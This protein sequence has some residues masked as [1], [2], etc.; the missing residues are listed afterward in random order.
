MTFAPAG[1]SVVVFD[2]ITGSYYSLRDGAAKAWLQIT[3]LQTPSRDYESLA[4]YADAFAARGLMTS[5]GQASPP[6]FD[7]GLASEI[8]RHAEFDHLILQEAGHD[9]PL[10]RGTHRA[11]IPDSSRRTLVDRLRV[12][13]FTSTLVQEAHRYAATQPMLSFTIALGGTPMRVQVPATDSLASIPI[14]E[15]F[16]PHWEGDADAADYCIT[17]IDDATDAPRRPTDFELDWHFPLGILGPE[18][19]GDSRVTVDRHTQTVSA[20]IPSSRQCVI[21]TK[22]FSALPYWFTATPLRLQLSWIAD[23]L[24][25]E[26]LHS[27]AVAMDGRAVVFAG[28][29]GAGKSTTALLLAQSG[30]PL[31][32]DDFLVA[33]TDDVQ[34]I[35]RRVKVHDDAVSRTIR[36]EWT[37]LNPTTPGQKRIVELDPV[38]EQT[39]MPIGCIVVPK[40]G[41][42][43]RLTPMEKGEALSAIAPA[44]MS[45]LLGG[46]HAS[47]SRI[48]QIVS[49]HPCFQLTVSESILHD[50]HSLE[51]MA[52]E[53]RAH[54][55][56]RYL[57]T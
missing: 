22:S 23:S 34:G 28:P 19:A 21:W 56:G 37:I 46:N 39:A 7:D 15:A 51:T 5:D 9:L 26:F 38:L 31:L 12:R 55:T 49:R 36:P 10:L 24:G 32:S 14:S 18:L 42:E 4:A 45:G 8:L 43:Y 20:F 40:V 48:A 25:L 17:F 57:S 33:S 52:R 47:L 50:A 13:R 11:S 54:A 29:S 53:L 41:A 30:F 6:E 1:G 35:Y 3:H 2:S 16:M 27:S 44:S